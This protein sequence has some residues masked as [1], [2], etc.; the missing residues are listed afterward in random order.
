MIKPFKFLLTQIL[1]FG[2]KLKK[3]NF[4]TIAPAAKTA[5]NK[6]KLINN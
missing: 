1:T 6:N 5:D 3:N 4:Q 2:K